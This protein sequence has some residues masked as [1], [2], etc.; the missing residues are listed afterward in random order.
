M[1]RRKKYGMTWAESVVSW[2]LVLV[3]TRVGFPLMQEPFVDAIVGGYPP[4][5]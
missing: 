2:S 5:R 3:V 1:Q 4:T